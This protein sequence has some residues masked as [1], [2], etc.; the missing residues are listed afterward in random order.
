MFIDGLYPFMQALHP[1]IV[2]TCM[3]LVCSGLYQLALRSGGIKSEIAVQRTRAEHLQVCSGEPRFTNQIN[4]NN[5]FHHVQP[6]YYPREQLTRPT[7]HI[8]RPSHLS[9]TRS[10]P[11][12]PPVHHA[13]ETPRA[14]PSCSPTK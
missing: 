4:T 3:P 14:R 1:N 10:P 5:L 9:Y 13:T 2:T 8:K 6:E 12:H 11:T 7:T